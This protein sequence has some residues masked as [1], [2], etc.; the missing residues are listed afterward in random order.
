MQITLPP[1][2]QAIIENE[3]AS[4]R[5]DTETDVI[6]EALRQFH[7]DVPQVPDE[8]LTEARA[9]ADRGE[10]RELTDQVWQEI[11]ERAIENARMGKPVRDE[12]KY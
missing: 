3:I 12:I 5:F 7:S 11:R 6:V 4:G 8:W 9:Q 10:G 2:A 1:E